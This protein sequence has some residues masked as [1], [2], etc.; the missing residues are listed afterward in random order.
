[1]FTCSRDLESYSSDDIA[2]YILFDRN[3]GDG[4]FDTFEYSIGD[5]WLQDVTIY[6]GYVDAYY[7]LSH[8]V[9]KWLAEGASEITLK[10]LKTGKFI[11]RVKK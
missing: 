4:Y 8:N 10:R 9:R 11:L 3:I 5:G 6:L 1:M 2:E 7:E